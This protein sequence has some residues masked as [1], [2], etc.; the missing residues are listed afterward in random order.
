MQ[1]TKTN[2]SYQNQSFKGIKIVKCN[3]EE[4]NKIMQTYGKFFQEGPYIVFKNRSLNDCDTFNRINSTAAAMEKSTGWLQLN[5][6]LNGIKLP[7]IENAPFFEISGK[8]V[9][10]TIGYRVKGLFKS[11]GYGVRH[12]E[13]IQAAPEHLQQIKLSNDYAEHDYPKFLKFLK[14]NNAEELSF[15]K[16]MEELAQRFG[17]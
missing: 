15:D 2:A 14:K 10:Q 3:I 11:I 13:E 9:L 8:D 4:Y 12:V 7:D 16:Y 1:V 17:K 5:C 6:K